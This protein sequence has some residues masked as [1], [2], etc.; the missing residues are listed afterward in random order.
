MATSCAKEKN[1]PTLKRKE[2]HNFFWWKDLEINDYY[3]W[4]PLRLMNM[5]YEWRNHDD[6]NILGTTPTHKSF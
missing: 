6:P 2:K 3:I 5:A 1:F 4:I